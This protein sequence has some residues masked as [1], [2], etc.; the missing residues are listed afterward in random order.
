MIW[1]LDIIRFSFEWSILNWLHQ[2]TNNFFN[3]FFFAISEFGASIG[4]LIFVTIIY[5]C[6]SKEKGKEIVFI[7]FANICFNNSLKSIFNAKRPFEYMGKEELRVLKNSK[8]SDSATGSSFPSGHAQNTSFLTTTVWINFKNKILRILSIVILILVGLS[9][10]YLGVH[11]P[12]DVIGGTILGMLT[13]VVLHILWNKFP[14]HRLLIIILA[15]ILFIPFLIFNGPSSK[16]LYKGMGMLLASPL[17][18][19]LEKK[20]VN[21]KDT[22]VNKKRI[23]RYLLGISIVGFFYLIIHLINHADFITSNKVICNFSNL[24]TH[25][26]LV[27]VGITFVPFLFNKIKGLE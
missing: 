26:L 15:I 23:L 16:D 22:K 1:A 17:A 9:R 13:T 7:A 8:L 5:W 12:L 19:I 20:Y 25:F 2:F 11:F 14:S 4:I 18:F 10:L 21:F 24:I 27:I 3:F 6:I